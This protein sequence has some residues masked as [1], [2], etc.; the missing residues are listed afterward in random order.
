HPQ[1]LL[2]VVHAMHVLPAAAVGRLQD[3]RKSDVARERLPI[4][5]ELQVA[6]RPLGVDA[7]HV[8]FLWEH[9][10][11]RNRD[12]DARGERV[13]EKLVVRAPPEWVVDDVRAGQR[14][15]FQKE[16]VERHLVAQPVDDDTV[17]VKSVLPEA[18]LDA[19]DSENVG[20]KAGRLVYLRHE[21]G[22]K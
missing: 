22:R 2:E 14:R 5:R 4:E 13:A 1:K 3:R 10:G 16:T 11:A 9:D 21:R 17:F 7:F 8:R 6:E 19:S 20:M 12:A 15:R 18:L